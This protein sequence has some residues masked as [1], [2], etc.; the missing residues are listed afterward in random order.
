MN[1]SLTRET[2]SVGFTYEVRDDV[3]D[4][5]WGRSMTEDEIHFPPYTILEVHEIIADGPIVVGYS[6]DEFD[7][8]IYDRW[9][10]FK[11]MPSH[12]ECLKRCE[13]VPN[14]YIGT[15]KIKT[16]HYVL[17]TGLHLNTK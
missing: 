13:A 6:V 1:Q 10:R 5:L 11:I 9:Q 15:E 17:N 3:E 7:E 4:G 8:P 16:H 12:F 2:C 14:T